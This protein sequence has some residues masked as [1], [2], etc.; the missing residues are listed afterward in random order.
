MKNQLYFIVFFLIFSSV[1]AANIEPEVREELEQEQEAS[2]IVI[3]KDQPGNTEAK[4]VLRDLDTDIEV[5]RR[6]S[7]IPGFSGTITANDLEKLEDDPRVE[8]IFLDKILHISLDSSVPLINANEVWNFSIGGYNITGK[9]ETVCILDTGIDTDHPAFQDK[10]KSQYCYCGGGCCPGGSSAE[11][12]AEDDHNPGHGTHVTGIAAGNLTTYQGVAKDAGIYAIKVCNSSGA[13]ATS[14]IL[15]GIDRCSD[16]ANISAFN[17]SV[18]SISLGDTTQ[19][20]AYCNGDVLAP[21]INTAVGRNVSVVIASGN[22]G[23]TAGISSPACVQNATPVGAVNDDDAISYNRGAILELLAPGVSI[24]SA[25]TGGGTT[26]LSGTSMSAPQA[27]GAIALFRQYWRLAY[28]RTPTVD[29]VK[30]KF[31]ITGKLI[32]DSSNSGKNYSRI[33]ILLALQ[34]FMNFT[35]TSAANN[36][37]IRANNS[38]INIT[39]DV[40]LTNSLLEWVYNNGSI[41]NI[42]LTKVNGTHFYLNVT[43]LLDGVDT[44]RV[45]GND[46]VGT[47]G[48]S[49]TRTITVDTLAPAVTFTNPANGSNLSSGTQAFNVTIAEISI[50]AVRF[51]FDNASGNSFNVTP[52]NRSGNW[53][54]N[55]NLNLFT[56]GSHQLTVLAND[57]AGNY[58]RSKVLDFTVDITAPTITVNI[59]LA[60]RNFSR[61]SSNQTFNLTVRDNLLTIASVRFSFNNFSGTGFNVSARNDSG[62]WILSYNVS[63]LAE[64]P[65]SITIFANDTAGNFNNTVQINFTVDFTSPRVTLNAPDLQRNFTFRSSNQTFNITIRD[66]N[67]TLS[68]V[69]VSFDNATGTGFNVT[70][71]NDSGYWIVNYNVSVL[72]NGSHSI[73]IFANDTVG[74]MNLTQSRSFTVDLDRPLLTLNSP[75]DLIN[76]SNTT[77][78]FN[79]SAEGNGNLANI[80]L[81]GNWSKGWHANETSTA[82][83]TAAEAVFSKTLLNGTFI[84]ACEAYDADGY[85]GFSGNRTLTIDSAPPIISVISSGTPVSTSTTITWTTNEIA[86]SSVQYGTALSLG[87]TSTSLSWVTVHSR[88][89]SSLSAATVYFYNVTSC[90]VAGNCLTNG[91]FNFTTTAASGSGDSGGGA[92]GGAAGGDGGGS[93][94]SVSSSPTEESGTETPS[95]SSS[96]SSAAGGEGATAEIPVAETTAL[97]PVIFSQTV[98][99]S[100]DQSNVVTINEDKIGVKRIEI[101][102]KVDK[103]TVVEVSYLPEKPAEIPEI[104]NPYQ[105]F[106]IK[107][108]LAPDEIEKAAVTFEVPASWLAENNFLKETVALN[109]LE[110]GKWK[111][112]STKLTEE[113]ESAFIYQSKLKHFS[114]FAITAHSELEFNWFKNLIPPQFGTR[115]FV[116]FGM[117][118]LIAFLLALYWFLHR[119]EEKEDRV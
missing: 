45:Y 97:E 78:N 118:L 33:D 79:C 107:V 25:V 24:T 47:I 101:D 92:G 119:G 3:L 65:H 34:P 84:W 116:I 112:L 8:S 104:R 68:G 55:I 106:E 35:D 12:N 96:E 114:Y 105:Y 41:I 6:Y 26:S 102:T 9:G 7:S 82:T 4:Q 91:T 11:A 56:E 54:A 73:T 98:S 108:D 39:S 1:L 17:I 48:S 74:N 111:K 85:Q 5:E 23:Y 31:M 40:N 67:L 93:G 32:D 77:V 51:S 115:G 57:T 110:D 72:A 71:R 16:S 90:D 80:T 75:A 69:L 14:D 113:S 52:D 36:S 58:D 95:P 63:A 20:N 30:R 94:A 83:G 37:I 38:F 43:R 61:S 18:I 22:S 59:P 60:D 76:R 117:I 13:C 100:K 109:T 28:S 49:A 42:T 15:S 29:E 66:T 27:A 53:N 44:Y 88:V 70:A 21:S 81:Y 87:S 2:V 19:N 50:D 86:N 89:L 62:Y 99:F 103:E 64:G 10:I 46:T